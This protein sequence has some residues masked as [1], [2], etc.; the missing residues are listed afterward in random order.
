M[1]L[2]LS[3]DETAL[4]NLGDCLSSLMPESVESYRPIVATIHLQPAI[5]AS[6][7]L[8]W[9]PQC[10]LKVFLR[11]DDV[12]E[13]TSCVLTS[14]EISWV[15]WIKDIKTQVKERSQLN[16]NDL[17]ALLV[18]LLKILLYFLHGIS[19]KLRIVVWDSCSYEVD[20]QVVS[21]SERWEDWDFIVILLYSFGNHSS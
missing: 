7:V 19:Y 17:Y 9:D 12:R 16:R 21:L 1:N 4:N 20:Y 14:T 5:V 13:S 2:S 10:L 15:C 3:N 6:I 11:W 8:A 18:S